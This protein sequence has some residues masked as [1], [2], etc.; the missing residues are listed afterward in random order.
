[1]GGSLAVPP[2]STATRDEDRFCTS[3]AVRV[4]FLVLYSYQYGHEYGIVPVGTRVPYTG[5][6]PIHAEIIRVQ[7]P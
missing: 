2:G 5:T 4:Q 7:V 3:T 6:V 1:M